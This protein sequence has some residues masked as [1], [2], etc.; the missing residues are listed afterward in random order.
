[1]DENNVV[2]P[3]KNVAIVFNGVKKRGVGGYEYGYGNKYGYGH[4]YSNE[5]PEKKKK[6]SAKLKSP[7]R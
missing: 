5:E 1:M 4:A 7:F 6:S 3:L 2:R